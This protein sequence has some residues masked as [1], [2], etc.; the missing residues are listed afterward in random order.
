MN[1]EN[2]FHIRAHDNSGKEDTS[3]KISTLITRAPRAFDNVRTVTHTA[4]STKTT[5]AHTWY[6]H[7][8]QTSYGRRE[9]DTNT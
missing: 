7:T 4:D 1:L 5:S 3:F 8:R 6:K 9:T 2:N